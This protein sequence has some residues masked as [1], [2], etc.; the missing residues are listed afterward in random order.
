LARD[1][2]F[3][4]I[5]LPLIP[6]AGG[7]PEHFDITAQRITSQRK[8]RILVKSNGGI[9]GLGQ[10]SIDAVEKFLEQ[11]EDYSAHFFNVTPDLIE[12]ITEINLK[13]TSRIT[14]STIKIQI[15]HDEMLNLFLASRIYLGASKSDG[16]STS[17]LEALMCGTY[18]IQ[19]N[20][21][22][23]SEWVILGASASIVNADHLSLFSALNTAKDDFLVDSAQQRNLEVSKNYL[24]FDRIKDLS[25]KFYEF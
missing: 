22:C 2:G 8:K 20:T 10:L 12:R 13:F 15:P 14:F 23:A 6:N 25:D 9:F 16:I 18:P 3:V 19:T 24:N 11:N 4:G 21:S 5:E 1:F 17:F 7:M